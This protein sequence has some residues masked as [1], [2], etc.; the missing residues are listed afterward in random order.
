MADLKA[1]LDGIYSRGRIKIDLVDFLR[2][3]NTYEAS[4]LIKRYLQGNYR[5]HSVLREQA[6]R[7]A[8][9]RMDFVNS[10]L[11]GCI[12]VRDQYRYIEIMKEHIIDHLNTSSGSILDCGIWKGNSTRRLSMLFPSIQIQAFD[13]LEGLPDDWVTSV[14]GTFKLS[15]QEIKDLDLPEN[16]NFYRGWFS[17]TL[18]AWRWDNS[19][20]VISLI[21]VDCDIYSST[22]DIFRAVG[23]MIGD[24]TVIVFDELIGYLGWERHEYK[25]LN[26]FLI[27]NPSLEFDYKYFGETY[28][29][30]II[31]KK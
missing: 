27:D 31:R 18:P 1:L 21:R 26:E 24:G 28:V 15:E 3:L 11:E 7:A 9:E 19:Y 25:A 13:S 10:H 16:S 6:D 5:M 2:Q 4:E 14:K 8:A 12:Y 30:G 22:R 20:K 29:A 17:D 23:D